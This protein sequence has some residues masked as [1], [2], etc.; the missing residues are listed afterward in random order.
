MQWNI[1]AFIVF[2]SNNKFSFSFDWQT[3]SVWQNNCDCVSEFALIYKQG[4]FVINLRRISEAQ[5]N[6]VCRSPLSLSKPLKYIV[7]NI[8]A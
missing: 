3:H 6:D 5:W 4:S 1:D 8:A 7:G 2:S